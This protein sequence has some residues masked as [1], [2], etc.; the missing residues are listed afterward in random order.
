M[1]ESKSSGRKY[2]LNCFQYSPSLNGLT[3]KQEG[4]MLPTQQ[5]TDFLPG[6][7]HHR[8]MHLG[9]GR[10]RI[11]PRGQCWWFSKLGGGYFNWKHTEWYALSC[12]LPPTPYLKITLLKQIKLLKIKS[13]HK[14]KIFTPDVNTHALWKTNLGVSSTLFICQI[15]KGQ[16]NKGCVL[17]PANDSKNQNQFYKFPFKNLQ[18]FE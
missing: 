7:I 15:E 3:A 6:S 11:Q 18:V 17:I 13:G 2:I 16:N 4:T 5:N 8:A 14:L 10:T 12:F 1:C 9:R